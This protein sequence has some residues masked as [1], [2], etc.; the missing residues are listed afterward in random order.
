MTQADCKIFF[1][2]IY[3]QLGSWNQHKYDL[4]VSQ[5][6]EHVGLVQDLT[7]EQH[8]GFLKTVPMPLGHTMTLSFDP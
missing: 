6:D 7:L 5:Y 3:N 2:K 4:L 8:G 1:K